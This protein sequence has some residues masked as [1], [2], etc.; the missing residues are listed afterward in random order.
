MDFCTSSLFPI[1]SLSSKIDRGWTDEG[2]AGLPF[3]GVLIGVL[4]RC[5]LLIAFTKTRFARKLE[6]HGRV[7]PEDDE[8]QS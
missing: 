4:C 8:R 5:G 7:V 2:A 3:L 6:R 1:R